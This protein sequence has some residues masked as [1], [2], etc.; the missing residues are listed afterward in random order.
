MNQLSVSPALDD[1]FHAITA[2]LMGMICDYNTSSSDNN[3]PDDFDFEVISLKNSG[4]IFDFYNSCKHISIFEGTNAR[5]QDFDIGFGCFYNSHIKGT[6]N[7]SDLGHMGCTLS[8]YKPWG[9]SEI[10]EDGYLRVLEEDAILM[11]YTRNIFPYIVANIPS[12]A[13]I[14]FSRGAS[15]NID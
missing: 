2:V 3:I 15:S 6:L 10:D 12:N 5:S 4:R 13:D 14:L 1:T 11:P 9:Q 7:A 8:H